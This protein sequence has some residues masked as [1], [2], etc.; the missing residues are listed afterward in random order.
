MRTQRE[1]SALSPLH[2]AS[3][4]LHNSL[5]I[6]HKRG[7]SLLSSTAKQVLSSTKHASNVSS[8]IENHDLREKIAGQVRALNNF[9]VPNK[10]QELERLL[11]KQKENRRQKHLFLVK[12]YENWTEKVYESFYNASVQAIKRWNSITNASDIELNRIID[13]LDQN[14]LLNTD[15]Q[16]LYAT[17]ENLDN[18]IKKRKEEAK[19]LQN[20][21]VNIENDREKTVSEYLD[22]LTNE[23][24]EV[25]YM[26]EADIKK[27]IKSFKD[28]T[29]DYISTKK[30]E[31][32]QIYEENL[33][34]IEESDQSFQSELEAKNDQWR[35]LNHN[36][37]LSQFY[38][39][40]DGKSFVNPEERVNLFKQLTE[41]QIEIYNIRLKTLENICGSSG[42]LSKVYIE[43][44]IE[45]LNI[46][47]DKVQA[48]YDKIIQSI[49]NLQQVVIS[50]L[51]EILETTTNRIYFISAYDKS[52]LRDIIDYQ[53][54]ELINK[55][56]DEWKSLLN[57]AVKYLNDTDSRSHEIV[58]NFLEFIKTV[59]ADV[60]QQLKR[61]NDEEK[62]Y[63]QELAAKE[64]LLDENIEKLEEKYITKV[65]ILKRSI[66]EPDLEK[67]LI[68]SVSVLEEMSKEYKKYTDEI[69]NIISLHPYKIINSYLIYITCILEKFGIYSTAKKDELTK[70]K[71]P[72]NSKLKTPEETKRKAVNFKEPEIKETVEEIEILGRKWILFVPLVDIVKD[73]MMTEQDKENEALKKIKEEE[74]RKED[75][76]KAL[77]ETQKREDLKKGKGRSF[78]IKP[79]EV[80]K[81]DIIQASLEIE[82]EENPVPIDPE[83]N[84][85]LLDTLF[86]SSDYVF[87]QI[88]LFQSSLI[89]NISE[90]ESCSI[91]SNTESDKLLL[92]NTQKDLEEKIKSLWPRKG[93]LEVNEYSTRNMQIKRHH[94]RWE[95]FAADF[96]SK[97][98][99]NQKE[100]TSTTKICEGMLIN[101]KKEQDIIRLQLLK[102]TSIAE[103]QGL[104]RKN[105]ELDMNLLYQGQD[106]INK[107][108]DLSFNQIEKIIDTGNDFINNL[109]LFENGG[110]YDINEVEYFKDKNKKI[111]NEL[112]TEQNKRKDI[113]ENLKKRLENERVDPVKS[114]EK[115]Y[116]N[117]I[118]LLAA[119]EG[120][121]KKYGA[122]KRSAQEKIRLEMTKCEKAQEGIEKV[123]SNLN[124]LITEYKSTLSSKSER[125][126]TTRDPSLSISIRISLIS[127][128]LCIHKYGTYI[129]AF[130]DETT[131]QFKLITWKEDSPTIFSTPEEAPL[132]PQRLEQLLD[133]LED[134][135]NYKP[136]ANFSQ[137]I[138]EIEKNAR[139]ECGKLYQ[140]KPLPEAVDKYFKVM[141]YYAEEFRINLC[142][143]LRDASLKALELGNS[144]TE[145]VF[146]SLGL[147]NEIE[148][149]IICEE[150]DK[151][152]TL[153]YQSDQDLR[154]LH[155]KRLRPNLSNLS[156]IEDLE[157]LNSNEL[158]RFERAVLSIKSSQEDF[159]KNIKSITE[160]FRL[161]LLNN[162]DALMYLFD[163]MFL[164]DDFIYI[165]GDESP[166]TKRSHIKDLYSKKKA[167][168]IDNSDPRSKKKTWAGASINELKIPGVE[169]FG[170]FPAIQSYKGEG[171][172][173][174]IM[175][176]NKCLKDYSLL[177]QSKVNE[178]LTMF[179]NLL[180][181][182]TLWNQKWVLSVE[183]LKSKNN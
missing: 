142:K 57:K 130:K 94:D 103:F 165:P 134:L 172:K 154:K 174:V 178:Y 140:G 160:R 18:H 6:E 77:E 129:S 148:F 86:I 164:Y 91:N 65:E 2:R 136:G 176:R 169:S 19:K 149:E 37:T 102:T 83:G 108:N 39:K 100:F 120:I 27:L 70:L 128:R 51:E 35:I 162:T 60:D 99:T 180:K 171:Q 183:I 38:D 159:I 138:A 121:G 20:S 173:A 151:K 48:E 8:F 72:E 133:P 124:A 58:S 7:K 147:G 44:Q 64:D 167:G 11:D 157:N 168:K 28:K 13:E 139:E 145:A 95:R 93:K 170:D 177:F 68:D 161:K 156:C 61:I 67:S 25:A 9:C 97:K 52:K 33:K 29:L 85:C 43:Q 181:D 112:Y 111:Y 150:I 88:S 144:I 30:F 87:S 141:K 79:E 175:Y 98:E 122:P 63:K 89:Q 109:Q 62:A 152:F 49:D 143:N 12:K 131:S 23:L 137:K 47:N 110:N 146:M 75:E 74:K 84:L 21:L 26:L 127:I 42:L 132:E 106:I 22:N 125:H 73:I 66:R 104:M 81:E 117:A 155:K 90:S 92:E 1:L 135:S 45:R 76:K 123:L 31:A 80:K 59:S 69:S 166:E 101:Y 54:S 15:I 56:K 107:L 78:T 40:V 34:K 53:C 5:T 115:D 119:R 4:A 36:K 16:T 113:I 114:F 50:E 105:K 71:K 17:K 3:I 179:D 82:K 14:K 153:G 46:D 10:N 182:E 116:N 24:I 96:A 126:F 163:S 158:K 41:K 118:E 32:N 55:R